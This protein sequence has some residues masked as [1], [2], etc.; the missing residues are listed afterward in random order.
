[1]STWF[2]E[3]VDMS[4]CKGFTLMEV[5]VAMA[6][7]AIALTAIYRMH[8]QTLFMDR[9]GRFDME[10]SLL[11]R[12]KLADIDATDP[13]ELEGDNG[14]FGD[15]HP[16]FTW[17]IETDAI[18]SDSLKDDGPG[19]KRITLTI[20]QGEETFELTTFRLLYE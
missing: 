9:R 8:T 17:R 5:V 4:N 2:V 6:I 19:L 10:A 16:D 13:S 20:A 7:V 3:R 11:A 1:M 15:L 18:T 14:D 12:Q